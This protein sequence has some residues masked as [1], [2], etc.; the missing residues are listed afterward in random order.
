MSFSKWTGPESNWRHT[1]FQAV[2]LPTE[3][4]VPIF[5]DLSN[6]VEPSADKSDEKLRIPFFWREPK[7]FLHLHRVQP[8][9]DMPDE[10]LR[11][12]PF[13]RETKFNLHPPDSFN[14]SGMST[15]R[16]NPKQER[17]YLEP[18]RRS[19]LPDSPL[20]RSAWEDTPYQRA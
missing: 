16:G 18:L 4:P 13:S 9:P 20:R 6:E 3:L 7:F 8:C 19:G 5:P 11:I 14:S 12:P 10:K 2:A 17:V 15:T 1:A